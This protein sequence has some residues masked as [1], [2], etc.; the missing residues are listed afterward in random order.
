MAKAAGTTTSRFDPQRLVR[1]ETICEIPLA[2]G[3][4]GSFAQICGFLRGLEGLPATIWVE[5]LEIQQA[6]ETG[7]DVHCELNLVVFS[8][9]SEDSDYVESAK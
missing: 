7:K 2:I 4:T 1:H 6:S 5:D 9:N 8:S 3:C